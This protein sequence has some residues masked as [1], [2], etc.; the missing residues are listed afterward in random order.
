M[1]ICLKLTKQDST[2][3]KPRHATKRLRHIIKVNRET[4]KNNNNNISKAYQ[5]VIKESTSKMNNRSQQKNINIEEKWEITNKID[6][7]NVVTKERQDTKD[8]RVNKEN[9]KIKRGKETLL[10]IEKKSNIVKNGMG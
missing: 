7:L 5:R 9:T 4:K 10:V 8:K 3:N 2:R 6:S 1:N